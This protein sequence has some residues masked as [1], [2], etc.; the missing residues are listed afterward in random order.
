M[1]LLET[2]LR[3]P[4]ILPE[5]SHLHP[6]PMFRRFKTAVPDLV[7]STVRCVA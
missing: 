3:D 5:G 1:P 4:F 6:L 7:R 2:D